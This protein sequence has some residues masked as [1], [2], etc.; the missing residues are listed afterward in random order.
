VVPYTAN[1][2]GEIGTA[3][4]RT[5]TSRKQEG[6]RT[7]TEGQFCLTSLDKEPE[8]VEK[9]NKTDDLKV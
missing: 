3:G 1:L 2:E 5:F 6:R 7:V 8:C 4:G 9:S